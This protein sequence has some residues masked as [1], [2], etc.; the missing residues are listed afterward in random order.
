MIPEQPIKVGDKVKTLDITNLRRTPGYQ[1]KPDSDILYAIPAKSEVVIVSGPNTA[2]GLVWWSV[3][4]TSSQGNTFSGWVAGAKASGTPLLAPPELSQP[5]PKPPFRRSPSHRFHQHP[6]AT[7]PPKPPVPPAPKPRPFAVGDKATAMDV[8][9]FFARPPPRQPSNRRHL[10]GA[11]KRRAYSCRRAGASGR[12]HVVACALCEQV[13]QPVHGL[14]A[15]YFGLRHRP[16]AARWPAAGPPPPEP[17]PLPKPPAVPP[18]PKPQPEPHLHPP[19]SGSA[20]T[21]SRLRLSICD[22]H[23]VSKTSLQRISSMRFRPS[24]R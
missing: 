3:R 1:D 23:R 22:A 2:D 8:V 16:A 9:T 4:F 18:E 13:W 7:P 5:R 12:P 6:A 15:C 10:P 20:T 17:E 14:G 19:P 11:S 24:L 21:R